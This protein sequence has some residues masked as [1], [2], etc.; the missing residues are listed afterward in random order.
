M[1]NFSILFL[2]L[3]TTNFSFS[4]EQEKD[5]DSLI[6]NFALSKADAQEDLLEEIISILLLKDTSYARVKIDKLVEITSPY[7]TPNRILVKALCLIYSS[8][9]GASQEKIIKLKTAFDLAK[10]QNLFKV[11]GIAK[12]DLSDVYRRLI[13]Y[14][15]A[16]VCLWDAKQYFEAANSDGDV[17]S[18][19]QKIGDYYFDADLTDNAEKVY[20]D[21]LAT[22]G[23]GAE[24]AW[25][26]YMYIVLNN[27][28]GLIE[29]KRQNYRKAESYFLLTMNYK[30]SAMKGELNKH[31]ST[32]L[33]YIYM[34]LAK[35]NYLLNRFDAA[36]K[37]YHKALPMSKHVKW[38]GNLSY[39]YILKA[40]L[41][42]K[43]RNFDSSLTY[44]KQAD[45]LN[46]TYN[47][48]GRT[49]EIYNT[50]A[51]IFE[52]MKDYK[53]SLLWFQKYQALSD[54]IAIHKRAAA[55]LHIRAEKENELNRQEIF[56]LERERMIILISALVI[57]VGII[58]TVIIIIK[59]QNAD[60]LLVN[61]NI[62]IIQSEETLQQLGASDV[63]K[64]TA[65]AIAEATSNIQNGKTDAEP[66]I[67][68]AKIIALIEKTIIE[69][70]L[71][72]SHE[73]NLENLAEKLSVNR[74]Y[75]SKAVNQV[76]KEN[77]NGFINELR[78]KESI[79]LMTLKESD[80]LS[81][82]GIA[83]SVGFNNR[84]SF[85]NAFKKYTGVT[86]SYFIRKI[87]DVA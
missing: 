81:I 14:D 83:M 4:A 46:R 84:T 8:Y 33:A 49:L 36:E 74:S 47:F 26:T 51:K 73:L 13:Q 16:M 29:I 61:K 10:S 75:L 27:N 30:L 82:E 1:R 25:N 77:F 69:D 7:S 22:G 50:Y 56:N 41:L 78:V 40:K 59:K 34:Q 48:Q 63:S 43:E 58:G 71:Y 17:L 65:A 52:E 70:K 54:S 42:M 55:F 31:D 24:E 45:E 28:L 86:P 15:S 20:K 62:E 35:V 23:K 64:A 66:Q 72:L 85:I 44:I 2:C 53:N 57:I 38:F 12:S 39:L 60:R 6:N 21:I 18:V 67:K 68:Y 19:Y 79:K 11:M 5:I 3:L 80:K 76:Y 9:Y 32:Q 87:S 37:Y